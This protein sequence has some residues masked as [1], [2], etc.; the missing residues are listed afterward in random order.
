MKDLTD[1]QKVLLTMIVREHTR[2]AQPV[3]SKTI[4]DNFGLA[5]SSATIRNELAAMTE[6]GYLRQPHTCQQPGP[7][8]QPAGLHAQ[9]HKPPVFPIPGRSGPLVEVGCLSI[10]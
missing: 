7:T 2:T 3:G 8:N 4:V 9:H 6:L 5:L 1:R 10:G